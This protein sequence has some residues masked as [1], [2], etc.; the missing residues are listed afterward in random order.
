MANVG[1]ADDGMVLIGQGR[2]A[3]PVFASL[4]TDSGLS[5]NG[6]VISQDNAAF[7]STAVGNS[8][9]VL[10]SNGA[11]FDP[12]FQSPAP[13]IFPWSDETSSKSMVVNSGY[14]T[15]STSLVVLTLPSIAA[16][17]SIFRIVG[18]G[19][20]G[21]QIAQN[22]GQIIHMGNVNTTGGALGFLQS[23]G[24]YDAIEILCT[25]ANTGFTVINGPQGNI[26]YN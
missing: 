20:G 12:S 8:G 15:S 5:A 7:T 17:G 11:G 4:G 23:T 9:Q 13:V 18:N 16:Y 2:L 25:T 3:G 19:T 10:T 21:W 6:V 24:T 1:T 14:T 26:T 22:A